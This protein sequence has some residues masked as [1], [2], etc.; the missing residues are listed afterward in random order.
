MVGVDVPDEAGLQNYET[1]SHSLKIL[2]SI[3]RNSSLVSIHFGMFHIGDI[4]HYRTV[5]CGFSGND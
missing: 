1:F 3:P 4:E 5:R 2:K